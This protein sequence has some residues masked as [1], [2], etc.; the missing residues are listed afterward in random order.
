MTGFERRPF[1]YFS[2]LALW[3]LIGF[4]SLPILSLGFSWIQV[5]GDLWVH[6][7]DTLLTELF[8]HTFQ[9]LFA[10]AIGTGFLGISLAW[11]VTQCEFPGRRWFEW[12]LFLPFAVPAYVLAFVFLGVLDYAGPL[13]SFI[14]E[15]FGVGGGVDIREG[16]WG[17]AVI[18]S[19]VFYPY[20]YL[21]TRSA[22]LSQP[23]SY[24]EVARSLGASPLQAF[25]RVSL[26]LARPAII[27]GLS[28]ALMEV[29]A[30]FGTVAMFNYDTFTTAIYSS[31][32]DYR[33]LETAAQ[34]STLLLII[35]A[36]LMAL[37]HYQRGKRAFH[38]GL[39]R[40]RNRYPLT[41]L[42]ALIT[43]LYVFSVLLLAFILPLVQ[44][45][46]WSVEAFTSW[47][48]RLLDWT[49][50]SLTL[51]TSAAL[52]T[53][54]IA[55]VLNAI[56]HNQRL[57]RFQALGIRFATLGYALP[58]SVLAI[59]V[60]LF[61]FELNSL[62]SEQLW[63]TSGLFALIT[64]Y[65]VRFL[66]VA[67]G[68]VES[69][70]KTIKPSIS[71]A[72]RNLGATP[73]ELMKRIYWPLLTPGIL[74]ALFLVTLD[75]LKELPATYLLRPFGWDTLAVRTF[76]LSTEGLYEAAALPALILMG[77]GLAGLVI[78]EWLRARTERHY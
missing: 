29:L 18:M 5:D 22:F 6:L 14:R 78:I 63:L 56:L 2:Q 27:A 21:L 35:A 69:S 1:H 52:I 70:F 61:L 75:I 4:V 43:V 12:L 64:A 71:E 32:V 73:I 44:L 37:E 48:P 33:S 58:G 59:G 13:Q 67:F 23:P 54:A 53:V 10:V 40:Q 34:L 9:L 36:T 68:P 47:D 49:R 62:F 3:C 45:T 42:K 76:E 28:L 30:D 65:V 8:S 24:T 26:P 66:A 11:L 17:I 19:L 15:T 20:V 55:L 38:S 60:M 25:F 57:N 50:N 72:A 16:V 74:T 77:I 7:S 39:P 46:L 41:G 31:W 51:A